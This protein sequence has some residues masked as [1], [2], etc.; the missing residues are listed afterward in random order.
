M[1]PGFTRLLRPNTQTLA[2]TQPCFKAAWAEHRKLHKAG[3]AQANAAIGADPHVR[4]PQDRYV[5]LGRVLWEGV[6]ANHACD[7]DWG[8]LTVCVPSVSTQRAAPA[9]QALQVLGP[10]AA[11]AR[12]APD[13]RAQ[14]HP[15]GA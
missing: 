14:A 12:D 8:G 2:H 1:M 7:L 10:A 11:L 3:G 9:V 6:G 4:T 15:A 5:R 13:D